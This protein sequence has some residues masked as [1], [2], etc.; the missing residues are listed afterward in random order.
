MVNLLHIFMHMEKYK[1]VA[2]DLA[3]EAGKIMRKNFGL[4]MKK[5]WKS[6]DTP[7]TETDL[8]VNSLV[9]KTL[10][11]E[12]PAHSVL[13][14][15]ES[16]MVEG[17]EYTWVCDPVDGTAPFS[18]GYPT[19][20]FSL[21][22]TKNGESVLGVIYDPMLDRLLVGVKGEG[23]TLNGKKIFVSKKNSLQ[24]AF[25]NLDIKK[26]LVGIKELLI[27]TSWASTIYSAVY[28]S[29]LVA[30]GEFEAEIFEYTS[31]WDAA[32][33]KII[34]EEAGGKVTDLDGNEQ[35]YDQKI[36]GFIASNGV[37]HEQILQMVQQ[38]SNRSS[39]VK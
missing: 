20:A 12:F 35:R 38:I 2:V 39:V 11:K 3:Y 36:N 17:S 25:I 31:P 30:C 18:H 26:R 32:A 6:D 14:E 34:I 22:L 4:G 10:L 1:K 28:V 7:L 5:E 24:N 21:A 9:I 8:D 37:L 13:G 16:R 29:M 19:F 23:A 15:E 33:V 27:D